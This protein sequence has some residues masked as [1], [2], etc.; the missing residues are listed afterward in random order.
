[1]NI[2]EEELCVKLVIDKDCTERHGQRTYKTS[3][4]L[5]EFS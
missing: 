1:M 4:S 2:D 3:D 5:N